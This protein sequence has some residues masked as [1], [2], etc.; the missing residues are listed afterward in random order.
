MSQPL[1]HLC[2]DTETFAKC[3]NSIVLTLGCVVFTF[4]ENHPYESLIQ[5]GFHIKFKVEDQIKNY[6]RVT[7]PDTMKWWKNQ[8]Q[9]A[10]DAAYKPLDTDVDMAEGLRLLSRFIGNSQYNYKQSFVWSR[11]PQF[12]FPKIES[13]YDQAGISLPFNS[14]KIRDTRT[15]TDILNGS[16]TGVYELRDGIPR[17]FVKHNAL[18]DAAKD[19][20]CMKEL[21]NNWAS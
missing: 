16:N 1:H 19:V 9:E 10:R 20:M 14:W 21:Y 11:G 7:D 3:E 8:S 6:H 13:M 15:I 17:G 18:H 12:D 5:N 4:E 2:I